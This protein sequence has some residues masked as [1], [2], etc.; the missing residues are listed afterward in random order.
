MKREDVRPEPEEESFLKIA[1]QLQQRGQ[2]RR[3]R[4]D[5]ANGTGV[6]NGSGMDRV[7][8]PE[9]TLEGSEEEMKSKKLKAT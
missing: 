2:V 1:G 5:L 7:V 6:L 4:V 3:T 8:I 9:V